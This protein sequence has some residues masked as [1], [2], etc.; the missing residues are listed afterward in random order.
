MFRP[1]PETAIAP[2]FSGISV[3][4][5]DPV[6]LI[7]HNSHLLVFVFLIKNRT[8]IGIVIGNHLKAP[9]QTLNIWIKQ[10]DRQQSKRQLI[11]FVFFVINLCREM[12]K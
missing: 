8:I 9:S 4:I 7:F 5:Y 6:L 11:S 12:E 10:D 3:N 2:G 1:M